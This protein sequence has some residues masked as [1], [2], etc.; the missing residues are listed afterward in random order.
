MNYTI[1]NKDFY[2]AAEEH[3]FPIPPQCGIH[4]TRDKMFVDSQHADFPNLLRIAVLRYSVG[5]KKAQKAMKWLVLQIT[6]QD[7]E[8]MLARFNDP[9][10]I[11][12][13]PEFSK[14]Y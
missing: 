8:K 7:R 10:L 9:S 12:K 5:C 6:Q 11:S 14:V 3:G 1:L 4:S 2:Y 13:N